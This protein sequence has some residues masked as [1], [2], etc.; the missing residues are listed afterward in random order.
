MANG[1]RSQYREDEVR[2]EDKAPSYAKG[3]LLTPPIGRTE[4]TTPTNE[5]VD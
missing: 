1:M 3:Y 4:P 2:A 5:G